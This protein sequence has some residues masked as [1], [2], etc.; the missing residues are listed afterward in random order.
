MLKWIRLERFRFHSRWFR[1]SSSQIFIRL[2]LQ[3]TQRNSQLST[4][5]N[6]WTFEFAFFLPTGVY[7]VGEVV[8]SFHLRVHLGERILPLY[9]L[10]WALNHSIWHDF[11]RFKCRK[12]AVWN[13]FT[14]DPERTNFTDFRFLSLFAINSN[15]SEQLGSLLIRTC[16]V[17]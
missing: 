8:N 17:L 5:K 12:M 1:L 2:R 15:S 13:K 10:F 11:I 9:L 16:K 4:N 14:L 6:L 3:P 7:L